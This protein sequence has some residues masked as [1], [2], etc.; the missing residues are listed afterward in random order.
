MVDLVDCKIRLNSLTLSDGSIVTLGESDAFIIVGPNNSGKS[1][2]LRDIEELFK[3]S[4]QSNYGG[5]VVTNIAVDAPSKEDIKGALSTFQE[6]DTEHYSSYGIRVHQN[7]VHNAFNVG[8]EK[9]RFGN[10]YPFFL[11]R[12]SSDD[13]LSIVAPSAALGENGPETPAQLLYD[14][15]ALLNQV[16]GI[17]RRA[18]NRDLFLDYRSGGHIPIYTGERPKVP[19][20]SDRVSDDYVALVRACDKLHEQGDGMKSFGGILLSTLVVNF[21]ITLI[22]EPEAFLHPPQER[23]IGRIISEESS[24]QILCSTHSK[25]VL[26][27]FLESSRQ[28]VRVGRIIREGDVNKISEISPAEIEELWKDPVFRYSPALDALFHDRTILCEADP[29]CRFYEA[30]ETHATPASTMDS[31]YVPCGGKSAYPKFIRALRKLSIPVL[32]VLDLDVLNDE[33]TVRRIYEAQGGDW[34]EVQSLWRRVDSAVRSG[35]PPATVEDTKSRIGSLLSNWTEGGAPQSEIIDA[36][37]RTKSWGKVKEMGLA[38]I[39]PGDAQKDVNDLLQL[40]AQKSI[41]PV[42]V[43]TLENFVRTVGNHGIKW[44]NEV[45]AT[46]S[47]DSDEL[48][49]AREFMAQVLA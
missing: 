10:S 23:I 7:Y 34:S 48:R 19:P 28:N 8:G 6:S 46:R 30:I 27:G 16:S 38:A 1:Q 13:R 41:F 32:A 42:P 15:E 5:K 43:G 47:L 18:F 37:K 21:N 40:L 45:L 39:P 29:D 9:L 20:G 25:D 22:D 2:L 17:F 49:P 33:E 26:Q 35:V 36:L 11:K 3:R 44:L 12:I 4:Y 14:N 24:G 31:H